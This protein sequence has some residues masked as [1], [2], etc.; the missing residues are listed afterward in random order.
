MKSRNLKI[1][2]IQKANSPQGRIIVLTGA[3]QTGKTTLAKN[4]FPE[5]NYLSI[6]DPQLRLQYKELTAKQW[7]SNYPKAIL[8]EVQ[9]E[10]VLIESIKAVYDQFREARYSHLCCNRGLRCDGGRMR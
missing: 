9:K 1:I 5:F 6:E 2:I 7:N 4:C 3:R 8:D 10:P